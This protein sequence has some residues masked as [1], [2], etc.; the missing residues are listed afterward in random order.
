MYIPV[1]MGQYDS[2]RLL[3]EWLVLVCE[4]TRTDATVD[5]DFSLSV[6][7][8]TPYWTLDYE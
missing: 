6:S 2:R 4:G 5:T 7:Q 1:T 3:N 8:R